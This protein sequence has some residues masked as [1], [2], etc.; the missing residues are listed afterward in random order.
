M[1]LGVNGFGRIGR[2]V[3][4]IAVVEMEL[5]KQ[6]AAQE[7]GGH[8]AGQVAKE[9]EEAT[10]SVTPFQFLHVSVLREYLNKEFC[11]AEYG[12]AGFQ[13]ERVIDDFIFLCFFVG[14]D[15]LSHLPSLEIRQ[16]AI[17]TLCDLYKSLLV[18]MGGYICDGGDVNVTRAKQ[19]CVGLGSLEDDLLA[20]R[21]VDQ[22]RMKRRENDVRTK[23]VTGRH[24][25]ILRRVIAS[26]AQ[27]PGRIRSRY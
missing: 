13:L 8:A 19:F 22:D 17:D 20:R 27:M 2:Q 26:A 7:D 10:A 11:D 6:A 9:A 25:D 12:D 4:R 21:K 15:F 1:K 5:E 14:N 23:A 24:A 18:P 3:V 16:G